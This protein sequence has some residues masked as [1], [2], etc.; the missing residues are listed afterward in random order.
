MI[1]SIVTMN[2]T[3]SAIGQY[4]VDLSSAGYN[5]LNVYKNPPQCTWYCWGRAYEKLGISLPKWGNAESWD[6]CAYSDP[7]YSVGTE[8][9]ANSIMVDDGGHVMF[10]EKIENGY[11][12][13]TEGNYLGS[14]FCL[15]Y[16]E[17][18]INLST[19]VRDS[20][21]NHVLSPMKY[22]YL[23]GKPKATYSLDVNVKYNG[24][25]YMCGFSGVTFDVYINGK[26]VA[27][28]VIDYAST[29]Y[30]GESYTVNDIRTSNGYVCKGATSFSGTFNGNKE[31]W[32]SIGQPSRMDC[33]VY[34]GNIYEFYAGN[35]GW[36]NAEA[37]A[38][39]K[40]GHLMTVTSKEEQNII[41][42]KNKVG[43]CWLGA[44]DATKEGSWRWVTGEIFGYTKWSSKQP[45]NNG[46]NEDYLGIFGSNKWN[47]FPEYHKDIKGFIVEYDHCHQW[48]SYE[49]TKAATCATTGIITYICSYCGEIKTETIPKTKDHSWNA[50]VTTKDPT[51]TETGVMTYTCSVCGATKTEV[52]PKVIQPATPIDFKITGISTSAVNLSWSAVSG[53][54]AYQILKYKDSTGEYYNVGSVK[55]NK[56]K[57]TGLKAG[58]VYKYVVRAYK[59][60]S[61]KNYCSKI[62]PKLTVYTRTEAPNI[63][64]ITSK[65]SKSVDLKWS[66]VNGAVKYVFYKSTDNKNWTKVGSSTKTSGRIPNLTGGKRIYIQMFA[67]N[68]AGYKSAA[69]NVKSI[70]VKK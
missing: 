46:N 65:A 38:E 27:N 25:K 13:I 10:V 6:D 15:E 19:M 40:G 11:A 60:I 67:L 28:N 21:P 12:Y 36:R 17:D 44:N 66:S 42:R 39:K 45:D 52:I 68:K 30:E 47:D 22:I 63:T 62:T 9:R 14:K 4:G 41:E 23:A 24:A 49:I 16:N 64:S 29:H 61:G 35:T 37:I 33:V 56:V 69:S 59:T 18:R 3:A 55:T 26:R 48:A 5:S 32:L 53:A 43:Y 50:G 1:L 2:F 7:N 31:V 34:K 20:W 58:T 70:V 54:T 57:I 51:L 8:P